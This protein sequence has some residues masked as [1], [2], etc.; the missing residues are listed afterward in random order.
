MTEKRRA[1]TLASFFRTGLPCY[2]GGDEARVIPLLSAAIALTGSVTVSLVT[3]DAVR[4]W[5]ERRRLYDLPSGRSSHTTPTPRGGG[6]GIVAGTITGIA[7]L[8]LT[9]ALASGSAVTTLLAAALLIAAVSFIDDIRSLSA[10]VRLPVHFIAALIAVIQVGPVQRIV[11]P[12][13]AI[14]LGIFAVPFTCLWIVGVT[15]AYNFMDGI[16]GIAGLQAIVAGAAWMVIANMNETPAIAALGLVIVG[17]TFGF[18]IR[19]WPP[20]RIFMGDVGSAFLGFLFAA[21]PLLGGDAAPRLFVPAALMLWP[22]LFDSA[23]TLLRRL[24]KRENIFVAHRSH[25]YQR[26]TI[27]RRS[28]RFV[29]S[30]YGLLALLGAVA[31]ATMRPIVVWSVVIAAAALWVFVIREER[32]AT[33]AP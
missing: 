9:G 32:A 24:G 11:L 25:L 2:R 14:D 5:T 8:R 19:N 10:A 17:A 26:L 27:A 30:L 29:T 6:A 4:R 12:D 33:P 23:F 16:D 31:A 28:H 13:H 15:N 21:L 18:L 22:F 3:V 7:L 20:A 1:E